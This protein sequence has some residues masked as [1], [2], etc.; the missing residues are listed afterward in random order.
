MTDHVGTTDTGI[1]LQGIW[2]LYATFGPHV[3]PYWKWFVLAYAGLIGTVLMNL[4]KPWPLKLIFDHILLDKPVPASVTDFASVFGNDK[5]TL[6]IIF[7]LSIVCVVFLDSLFSYSHKYLIAAAG[8][9]VV[10]DIRRWVFNHLQ[11]LPQSF[12]GASRSGDLTLRLTSDINAIKKLL[13]GSVQAFATYLLT[14]I[15]LIGTMLWM[16][17]RLTL[18]A[19]AI[20]PPLYVMSFRFSRKVEV[21]E[22]TKRAKE[23]EVASIVQETMVSMPV[24]QAFT[25][26]DQERQ[27]FA[28][29]A[30]ESLMADLKKMRLSRTLR[31]AVQVVIASG[32]ALVVWYGARRA[33]AGEVTPGDLIVFAAYLKDVYGPIGGFSELV[34]DFLSAVVG[35]E[36][37]AAIIGADMTVKDSPHAVAAPPFRGAVTF[38]D[39]TFGYKPGEPVLQHL[40]FTVN[41]GQMVALVGFS[42][43]G[44]STIVNLL[45]RFF[46]PWEGRILV[47][48]EDIRRF[49]LESV[50]RQMSVVL[51]ESILFRR[52]IGENIAYGNPQARFEDIV[53][54]A[55]AAQAQD[56][57]SKLPQGYDTLV[58]ERGINLSGGQRQRLALA[59]AILRN[60]PLL[61][62]DEP[63]TGLDAMTESQLHETLVRLMQGKT[64]FVI[65]HRLSTIQKADVILVIDEGKII[66]QGTHAE[67]LAHSHLYHHLYRLQSEQAV[68]ADG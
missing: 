41:P 36:R 3:K 42:G 62:L 22:K 12:H 63:V 26:E 20:V 40:S 25:Q 44:K 43:T 57:I 18:V 35:S 52:T 55:K 10:N 11:I 67:L 32:T 30:D 59:R 27:R 38:E 6:L 65:A 37:I 4:V 60:A 68:L 2:K 24:V 9:R 16:D 56:F 21:L 34:T 29:A 1:R 64:T 39:V 8:E 17:W 28:R 54:A 14:F 5:S 23:S 47:D 61:I 19:L 7:C 50:R 46:D 15:S 31:R 13:I 33:L 58:S 48:G 45:L 53:A 49:K 66:E 51:Q